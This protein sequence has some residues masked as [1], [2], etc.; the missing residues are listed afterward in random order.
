[1]SS[2]KYSIPLNAYLLAGTDGR[3]IPS[4]VR[5]PSWALQAEP[6]QVVELPDEANFVTVIVSTPVI[7]KELGNVLD[8]DETY[9]ITPLGPTP[10]E[11]T[12]YLAE[13]SHNLILCRNILVSGVCV[14]NGNV[15]WQQQGPTNKWRTNYGNP[16]N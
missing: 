10:Q 15:L 4:E 9:T 6:H 12:M 8:P 5:R 16:R 7:L 14:I 2:D 1:M 13:G 11:R 3:T